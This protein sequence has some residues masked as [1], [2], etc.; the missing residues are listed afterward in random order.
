MIEIV[1]EKELKLV[2][3]NSYV[4][5]FN[6]NYNNNIKGWIVEESK[7]SYHGILI[8]DLN[9]IYNKD[10]ISSYWRKSTKREYTRKW[11]NGGVLK[12]YLFN[13]FADFLEWIIEDI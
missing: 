7:N 10:S 11:I 1:S 8:S 5:I 12:A 2:T 9:D 3:N 6:N 13:S 4:G